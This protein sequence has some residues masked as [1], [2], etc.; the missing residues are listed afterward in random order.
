MEDMLDRPDQPAILVVDDTPENLELMSEL[1]LLDDYR[2]KVASSGTSALRIALEIPQPD[3]ILLD[4]MMPGMD[5]YEVCRMLKG[6]PLT[7]AIPVIFL[8]AKSA[9]EDEQ[10]GLDVGAVDYIAKPISPP[11]VLAR[12]KSH[13]QLK[14]TADFLRDKSE[15]L[16]LEVKRRTQEIQRLH[17]ATIEAMAALVDMRD[18]PGGRRLLR[19]E[20]YVCLL[21]EALIRRD[22]FVGELGLEDIEVLGKSALLH[23]IGKV[24]LPDRVLLNPGALDAEDLAI[25][26]RHPLAGRDAL[27]MAERRFGGSA[28][29]LHYAKEITYGHHEHWDGSGFPQG[30]RG[31]AIPLS[32]RIV[33]LAYHYDRLTSRHPYHSPLAPEEAALQIEAGSGSLFD[34]QL[35]EVFAEVTEQFAVIARHLADTDR[36]LNNGLQ[37]IEQ[38]LAETIELEPPPPSAEA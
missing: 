8:T 32:A 29:F 4:I 22:G 33:T 36:S 15:Y 17:D 7:T 14:A 35:V 5:G 38:S 9:M 16:E 6:N 12:V 23:D 13:L 2:V 24:I 27:L 26:H 31:E 20:R 25:L 37:R 1:L 10:L 30:L 3:L 21:A 19:I 34:P 28:D 11:V 18:S